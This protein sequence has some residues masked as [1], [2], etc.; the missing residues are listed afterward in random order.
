MLNREPPRG[1]HEYEF[2]TRLRHIL[3]AQWGSGGRP[4]R[5][6]QVDRRT[7]KSFI[8]P[9]RSSERIRGPKEVVDL[10]YQK[11]PNEHEEEQGGQKQK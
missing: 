2:L 9:R 10:A 6:K 11:S 7:S 8:G 5:E 3:E 1:I 4:V